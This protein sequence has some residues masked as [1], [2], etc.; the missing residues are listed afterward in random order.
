MVII[1]RLIINRTPWTRFFDFLVLLGRSI[2]SHHRNAVTKRTKTMKQR[3][4]TRIS[5]MILPFEKSIFEN[6]RINRTNG[7]LGIVCRN[8]S[9]KHGKNY[10]QPHDARDCPRHYRTSPYFCKYFFLLGKF[11]ALTPCS[12]RFGRHFIEKLNEDPNF[13][14]FEIEKW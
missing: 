2:L 8:Y 3:S 10:R 14:R 7:R 5:F 4:H 6:P 11:L 13:E 9:S 1:K 12:G